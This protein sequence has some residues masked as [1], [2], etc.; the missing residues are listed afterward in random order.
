[1]NPER[2]GEFIKTELV[3]W[4]KVVRDAGAKLD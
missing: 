3:R 2:F 4:A 1:M